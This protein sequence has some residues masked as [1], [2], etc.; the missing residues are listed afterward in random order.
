MKK[1]AG[2]TAVITGGNSGIGL[3]TAKEF[4]ASGAKVIITGRNQKLIDEAVTL[5]GEN[6]SGIVSDSGDMQQV[7]KLGN[8]IKAIS[9]KIDIIFIN[10][11]IAQF[12]T[13]DQVT[14]G[15]FDQIMDVNFKGAYF[16]LQQLL[17]LTNDGGSVI[18]NT[19]VNAHIGMQ[20]ASVYAAS[21]AA[22]ISL[23]KNLSLELTPRKIRVNSI[24]PG[25]VGTPM[26]ST[27][28]LGVT[29]EQLDEIG[30]GLVKQI[31]VGR[32][33]LPEE[34]AKVAAFLASDDSSFM[35]GADLI[36]DGGFIL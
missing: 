4:I 12:S 14:E 3:A 13:A 24:S 28:K 22:L 18:F 20:G 36:V 11:G 31:P 21:K 15:F 26:H 34:I 19:S 29:A 25:P 10:A 33:G 27:A 8:Q 9:E 7:N 35:L 1:L 23:A 6:A 2:K 17:P 5:L 30:G 16:S 32:F